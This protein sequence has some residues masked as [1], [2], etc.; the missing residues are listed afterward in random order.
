MLY[1][2]HFVIGMVLAS[3]LTPL[4]FSF[5][6]ESE[7][8]GHSLDKPSNS[9]F[10]SNII[11]PDGQNYI[12][13]Y[14]YTKDIP[15]TGINQSRGRNNYEVKFNLAFRAQLWN[16]IFGSPISWFFSYHQVS[17]WQLY[18]NSAYFR[19]TNYTPSTYVSYRFPTSSIV[20]SLDLGVVHQSNGQGGADE[21]SW[22]RAFANVTFAYKKHL[23]L[24]IKP[25]YRID[26][27]LGMRDYNPD[28]TDYLGHGNIILSYAVYGNELTLK[29]RNNF[30]SGFKRGAIELTW[31]FPVYKG[32][33][34]FVDAFTGYGQSLIEYNQYTNSIG[35][36]ID[37]SDYLFN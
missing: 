23:L 35:I 29:S 31:S 2:N 5:A 6:N 8:D 33:R 1:R 18:T 26:S 17:Y 21:R 12:L 27:A 4:H 9:F 13:P 34:G 20:H 28:I 30:E 25:W 19:E 3:L 10:A 11:E 15:M 37:F 24:S 16:N 14:F 32:I 22:N 36:G 7:V